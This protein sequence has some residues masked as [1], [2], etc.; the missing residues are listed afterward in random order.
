MRQAQQPHSQW[1]YRAV[2]HEPVAEAPPCV[3]NGFVTFGAFN[4]S[5]KLSATARRLWAEILKRVPGSQLRIVGVP[6]GPGRQ[7]VLEDFARH[8]V[9]PGAVTVEPRVSF[10][11]YFRAIGSVDIALD[12]MPYSGG[13]TTCD[14]LWMGT[15]VLTLTGARSVSRSASS[16]LG[17]L[18]LQ[19]WIAGTPEE[20]VARAVAFAADTRALAGLRRSLRP[21]MEGSPLMDEPR[22]VREM[23]SLYRRIWRTWCARLSP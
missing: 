11:D 2:V 15:P 16:A 13:T 6:P 5:A 12:T 10:E 17:V 14:T 7:M 22:F 20:Y 1:C 19:E 21:R 3:R 8:G 4:Q 18:G 23:E 9:A